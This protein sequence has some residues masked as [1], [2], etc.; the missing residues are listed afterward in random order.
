MALGYRHWAGI[1][2][3]E[4]SRIK[5][6]RFRANLQNCPTALD[7]Y[8][9]AANRGETVPGAHDDAANVV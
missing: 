1:S 5:H 7:Y 8:E 6:K 9:A 2:V 3:Q 4:V